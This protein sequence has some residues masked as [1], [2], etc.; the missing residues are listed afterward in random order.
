VQLPSFG[1]IFDLF[2]QRSWSGYV[3]RSVGQY[4]NLAQEE[5]ARLKSLDAEVD[6]LEEIVAIDRKKELADAQQPARIRKQN[7]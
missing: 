1:P 4:N 5:E 3:E 2:G 7:K 6:S